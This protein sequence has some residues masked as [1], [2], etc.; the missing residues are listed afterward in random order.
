MLTFSRLGRQGRFANGLFQ[1]AGTIGIAIKSNQEY[2]FPLW[3]NYDHKERFGSPE[4]ID[5]Y[6]YFINPLP[7][8]NPEAYQWQTYP[9]YWGYSNITFPSG[10]WD[11]QS[12]FQ[13]QKYFDHCIDLIRHYFTM[14]DEKDYDAIA[15]HLRFGDYDDNY[16][17]RP[18]Q[19]YYKAALAQMPKEMR[20]NIFSDDIPKAIE[21]MNPL[22]KK[23][24]FEWD[25]ISDNYIDSF[26]NM[27]RHKHFICGNSSYS[28]MAAILAPN[29]DKI[30]VCPKN[31]F[32]PSWGPGQNEIMTKDIYPEGAIII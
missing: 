12:H 27:K 25:G 19:A 31:F 9:Y 32:G 6:K 29:P 22:M 24:K 2:G 20:V 18:N 26:R 21:L 11:L 13:S 10:N 1:I 14:N 8:I 3:K 23:Y 17:P 28:L 15:C 7:T 30:I 5:L 16:H 4:D